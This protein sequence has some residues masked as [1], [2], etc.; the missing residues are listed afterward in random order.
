MQTYISAVP[1]TI[2]DRPIMVGVVCPPVVEPGVPFSCSYAAVGGVG[3]GYQ[4]DFSVREVD[5][6]D[7]LVTLLTDPVNSTFECK[8]VQ[9]RVSFRLNRFTHFIT[10]GVFVGIFTT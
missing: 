9:C 4:L 2:R 6:A 8:Q 10:T 1:C 7:N 5:E 3:S